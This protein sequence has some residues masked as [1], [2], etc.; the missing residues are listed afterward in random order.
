MYPR[1]SA[2]THELFWADPAAI[3]APRSLLWF[4]DGNSYYDLHPDGKRVAVASN[5][6]ETVQD[7]VVI[8][9]N[10]FD[11]LRTIAPLKP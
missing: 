8:M 1:W 7:H 5:E 6:G 4:N 10:F 2:A 11:Y 3:W 9:S